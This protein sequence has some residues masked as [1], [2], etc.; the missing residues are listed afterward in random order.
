M[1]LEEST[2]LI[3][4]SKHY[5]NPHCHSVEEFE[6]DIKRIKYIKK[7]F[8][9]Y[10]QNGEMNERLILNHLII[11]YNCFGQNAIP[12]LFMKL[13]QYHSVLKP[14]VSYLNVLPYTI[15]YNNTVIFTDMIMEDLKIVNILRDI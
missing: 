1:K 14:F 8:M 9:K 4:A 11:F 13:E 3:Y 10:K 2:F 15:E 5:D 6:E 7:L 12:M